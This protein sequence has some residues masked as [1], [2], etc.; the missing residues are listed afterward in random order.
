LVNLNNPGIVVTCIQLDTDDT[1]GLSQPIGGQYLETTN[2]DTTGINL[3]LSPAFFY[4]VPQDSLQS[5]VPANGFSQLMGE[6][7]WN[8]NPP[9]LLKINTSPKA[10][11]GDYN[12]SFIFTYGDGQNVLQDV[13]TTQIH[14]SSTWE[15]IEMPLSII[16]IVIALISLVTSMYF[17]VKNKR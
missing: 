10:S 8:N 5:T 7:D 6:A 17:S 12:I 14:V 11:S 1:T 4:N 3:Y 2:L 9:I 15:R 16:A 13:Q